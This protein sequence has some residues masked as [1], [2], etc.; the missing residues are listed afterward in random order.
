[1]KFVMMV[2][3]YTEQKVIPAFLKRWLN[4]RLS[5]RVGIQ[6]VRF[7]GWPQLVDDMPSRALAYLASPQSTEIIAVIALL[8]LVWAHVLSGPPGYRR[9]ALGLGN[10]NYREQDLQ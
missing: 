2:E 4:P 8:D 5:Q 3:G 10:Q 9:G 6:I 1:M 7:E